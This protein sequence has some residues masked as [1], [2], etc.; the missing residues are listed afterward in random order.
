M[1][2]NT[3]VQKL[4]F[5]SIPLA[6]GVMALKLFAW[7]VTGSVAL[8]SDA[9]ES[10]VN[11]IAALVAFYVI[12]Y[13]QRPADD[14]HQYGHHKAEYM[15]AVVE[16]VL[17]I[18]AAMLI[19]QEAW[20]ALFDPRLPDAPVLGLFINGVAGVINF[21]WASLLIRTGKAQRSP[22]L[23][24]DGHHIMS[25]V[26]TSGGVLIGLILA[27]VTGYAILDPLMAIF[28]AINILF[29]GYK[30][31][32]HSVG[33]L[34]DRALEQDDI[35]AVRNAI[36][37]NAKGVL[38]VHDLRTRQA[39]SAAFVAFHIVVPADMSVSNAHDICDRMED[40][41]KAIVP[42]ASIAIHVEPESERAHGLR[43]E[44]RNR[45]E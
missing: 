1:T 44:V 40:A 43:V 7:Y 12:R 13:A 27:I 28:V 14:D 30:V 16:G 5:W 33:G 45:A 26:V 4:A 17:I 22:A 34:M 8:L 9:L 32:T 23:S 2:D 3:L 41:I 19:V 18:V 37:D 25:D 31:I 35:E 38:D 29:Q 20:G 11:I 10:I 6:V 15:S 39:G 24:A 21:F 42:G 36:S